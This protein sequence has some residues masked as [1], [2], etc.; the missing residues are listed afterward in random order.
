MPERHLLTDAVVVTPD[1]VLSGGTVVVED[2]SIVE[3]ADRTYP[4]G[5][6]VVSLGGRYLLPGL[7]DLHNDAIE[8]EINPRPGAEFPLEFALLQL[9][10]KLAAAGVTT[11]FHAVYF[12]DDFARRSI[13]RAG[14]IC[15]AIDAVRA[16]R[17]GTIEHH[18]MLRLDLRSERALDVLL[19]AL[20]E[21]PIALI[22]LND[23]VP[24]QGQFRDIDAYRRYL[25]RY[26]GK[27]RGAEEVEAMI[28]EEFQRAAETEP[29]VAS[30]LARLVAERSRR[31]L[32]LVSHDDDTPERVDFMHEIGCRIAEFPLTIE[33]AERAARH[34]MAIAAG[35][36]NAF[37]GGSLSGNAGALDLIARGLVDI[38]V[39]DY[40]AP[41]LLAA[42]FRIVA[43]GLASLPEATRFVT[44]NPAAA[45][46]LTDRG[47]I[48]AG[49]RA[50]LI[51]VEH[52]RGVPLTAATMAAGLWRYT[53]GSMLPAGT[54]FPVA[55]RSSLVAAG[56]E[57]AG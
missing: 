16:G 42:L 11:Q 4:A 36:P 46:G 38:L 55:P 10:R 6:D 28:V 47:A 45:V 40:H 32:I 49:T 37:R 13:D 34:G 20:E 48:V 24:G 14:A 3:V 30:I 7:V 57:A 22:S 56:Q 21:A 52:R 50:D 23:H 39:A 54:V 27:E 43:L 2:G 18:A 31:D 35:S 19:P 17:D 26:A 29:L 12:S 9:D 53:A 44:L 41:S 15:T 33:A 51:V 8:V 25:G 5:P 1:F